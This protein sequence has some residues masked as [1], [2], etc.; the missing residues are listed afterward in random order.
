MPW[1]KIDDKWS[2]HPKLIIVGPLGKALY[3]DALCYA[4]QYLTDGFIPELVAAQLCYQFN[5]FENSGNI[6]DNEEPIK[7]LCNQGL[8]DRADDERGYW[9]HDYLEFNPSRA[10][11][12]SDRDAAK[13]RMR[14]VRDNNGGSSEDVRQNFNKTSPYPVPVPVPVVLPTSELKELPPTPS[15][16][17]DSPKPKR[18][19]PV[20]TNLPPD[21]AVTEG[22]RQW[23]RSKKSLTDDEID[24]RTDHFLNYVAK[25]GKQYADWTAAWRDSMD[26]IPREAFAV[27]GRASPRSITAD[28]AGEDREYLRRG[29]PPVWGK[30]QGGID[31][32]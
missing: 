23:A 13:A 4:S 18:S 26:W 24:R 15:V 8:W 5:E 29:L 14:R 20:L 10:Q 6:P 30:E 2:N 7:W 31:S 16:E 11:V 9:I 28:H 19:K 3:M 12:E 22:M 27:N 1:V 25:T 17:G 32:L 21:F